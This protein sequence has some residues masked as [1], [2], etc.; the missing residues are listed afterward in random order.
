[1]SARIVQMLP[2]LKRVRRLTRAK[3]RK[4]IQTCDRDFMNCVCN[5]ARQIIKGRAKIK[6][7]HFKKL[8]RHKKSLRKLILKKTSLKSKRK[9]LQSGGF[10]GLLLPPIL[11]FL[12][13]L[14]SQ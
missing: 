13:S 8:S 14:I 11:G 7:D 9:I 12:S 1:M 2:E 10:L 4:F 5:C 6:S 3:Q